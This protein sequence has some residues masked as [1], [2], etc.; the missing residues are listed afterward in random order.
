M[1]PTKVF[2]RHDVVGVAVVEQSSELDCG[3][4]VAAEFGQFL[5]V[6]PDAALG[7]IRWASDL[8]FSV[9]YLCAHVVLVF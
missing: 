1:T 6:H 3:G 5:G 7:V 8:G 2:S 4:P 9:D